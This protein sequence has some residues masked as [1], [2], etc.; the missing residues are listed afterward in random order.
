MDP[1]VILTG[2]IIGV[3]GTS[4]I[5]EV[6]QKTDN[7]VLKCFHARYCDEKNKCH[8]ESGDVVSLVGEFVGGNTFKVRGV[9]W[10]VYPHTSE[11]F[12]AFLSRNLSGQGFDGFRSKVL[13][14][15]LDELA[16]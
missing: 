8:L 3:G 6:I 14:E 12:C 5:L 1:F 7:R 9:A 13:Y 2:R 10:V 16:K 4:G 11:A 15:E